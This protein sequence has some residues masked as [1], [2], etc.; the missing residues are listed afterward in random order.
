MPRLVCFVPAVQLFST[1]HGI[2][3]FRYGL[4]LVFTKA[5][6]EKVAYVGAYIAGGGS[7]LAHDRIQGVLGVRQVRD[8]GSFHPGLGPVAQTAR[9]AIWRYSISCFSCRRW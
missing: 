7:A 8:L 3:G 5:P 4:Y 1:V 6:L 9:R 2:I